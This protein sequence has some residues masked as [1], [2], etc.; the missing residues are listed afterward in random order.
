MSGLDAFAYRVG[1]DIA[2]SR[3]PFYA[4][5]VAAM[6]GADSEN[7]AKLRAAFPDVADAFVALDTPAPLRATA[8]PDSVAAAVLDAAVRQD[9]R[10]SDRAA[11][12]RYV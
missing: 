3:P 4:L 1:R 2:A 10:T 5:I 9:R 6:I 8:R 7:A 11:V 12:R